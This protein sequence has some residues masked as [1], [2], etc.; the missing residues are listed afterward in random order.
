MVSTF[1]LYSLLKQPKTLWIE[2][3]VLR[4]SRE[5]M[6]W[7]TGISYAHIGI[8]AY[9]HMHMKS[10]GESTV[11]LM[12][13]SLEHHAHWWPGKEEESKQE[14]A[15]ER[16]ILDSDLIWCCPIQNGLY[17][18][19]LSKTGWRCYHLHSGRKGQPQ[20]RQLQES[21]EPVIQRAFLK[22]QLSF[23]R[24]DLAMDH[25]HK[26]DV[27]MIILGLWCPWFGASTCSR[28]LNLPGPLCVF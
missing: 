18:S 23:L 1:Q 27:N 15:E 2:K 20:A 5:G 16:G 10:G 4:S 8:W 12:F 11:L 13:C 28:P 21:G 24:R 26:T 25:F 9:W 22:R 17:P 7:A 6:A 19:E 14:Q 3:L